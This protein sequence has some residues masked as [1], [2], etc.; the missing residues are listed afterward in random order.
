MDIRKALD[1]NIFNDD[2]IIDYFA[3]VYFEKTNVSEVYE[4]YEIVDKR[5]NH[6]GV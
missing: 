4:D 6:G 5:L 2:D 1:K 3:N